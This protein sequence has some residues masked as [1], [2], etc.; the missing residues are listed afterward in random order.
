MTRLYVRSRPDEASFTRD[1]TWQT[2]GRREHVHGK[3]IPM[4]EPSSIVAVWVIGF[5]IAA[6]AAPLIG[7]LGQ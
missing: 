7:G 4:E 1:R 5:A 6:F 2:P 3:L